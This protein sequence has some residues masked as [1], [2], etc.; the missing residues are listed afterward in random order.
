[1]IAVIFHVSQ[2]SQDDSEKETSDLLSSFLSD[3][4]SSPEPG[5]DWTRA[6]NVKAQ[7]FYEIWKEQH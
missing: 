1:M 2:A 7:Y 5:C 6:G 3:S 4:E